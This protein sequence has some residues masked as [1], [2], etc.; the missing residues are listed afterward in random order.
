MREGWLASE[1]KKNGV[2]PTASHFPFK[3][4]ERA[5]TAPNSTPGINEREEDR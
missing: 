3:L 2:D 5:V 1:K 4:S